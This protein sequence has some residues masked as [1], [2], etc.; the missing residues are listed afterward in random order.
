MPVYAVELARKVVT[1][2]VNTGSTGYQAIVDDG[3][4]TVVV[5]PDG[6]GEG[7][8]LELLRDGARLD[9][10]ALTMADP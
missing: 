4:G 2:S 5:Q 8:T 9:T 3:H 6:T 10:A 1:T 7:Y